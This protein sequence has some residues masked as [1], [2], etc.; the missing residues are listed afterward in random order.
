[1][2][3][4]CVQIVSLH[5]PYLSDEDKGE[6]LWSATAFPFGSPQQLQDQIVELVAN[7]DGTLR[8]AINYAHDQ[9]DAQIKRLKAEGKW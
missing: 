4:K 8:S 5:Y 3:M 7:T 1:M 2:C 9:Q 6:L